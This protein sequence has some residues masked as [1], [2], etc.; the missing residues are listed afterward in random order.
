MS[1]VK[2]GTR[3]SP[4][5][6][7]QAYWCRDALKEAHPGLDV[8]GLEQAPVAV[9]PVVGRRVRVVARA[10]EGVHVGHQHRQGAAGVLEAVEV[11]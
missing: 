8:E 10:D 5:A 1:L 11:R 7:W 3:G 9:G 4:L 2:L 6:L